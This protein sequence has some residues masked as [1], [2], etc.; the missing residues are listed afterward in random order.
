MSTSINGQ[1]CYGIKFPDGYVFP[2]YNDIEK[3]WRNENGYEKPFELY[4]ESDESVKPPQEKIDEYYDHLHKWEDEH[5]MPVSLVNY[6]SCDDP[7]WIITVPSSE[8]YA[9]CGYPQEFFPLDFNIKGK[10]IL[11]LL[12]FCDKYQLVGEGPCWWLSSYWG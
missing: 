5:R 11:S 8:I 6:Q 3:W 1:I 4:D 12:N 9:Q 7:L 10:D 2:W